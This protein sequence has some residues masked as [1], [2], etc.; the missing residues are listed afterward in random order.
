MKPP[1]Q[2]QFDADGRLTANGLTTTTTGQFPDFGAAQLRNTTFTLDAR[3][4][5]LSSSDPTNYADAQTATYSGLG[6]ALTSN[7]TQQGVTSNGGVLVMGSIEQYTV[8]VMGNVLT[9]SGAIS[10]QLNGA[11]VPGGSNWSYSR[12]YSQGRITGE[13]STGSRV[14]EYDGAGSDQWQKLVGG[15]PASPSEHRALRYGADG[16][17][18]RAELGWV[19]QTGVFPAAPWKESVEDYAYDALGRRVLVAKTTLCVLGVGDEATAC[20]ASTAV[21][22]TVWDGT[23]ELAEIQMPND[24]TYR[25]NDTGPVAVTATTSSDRNRYYGRVV[26]AHGPAVDQPLSVTRF[27]YTDYSGTAVVEWPTFTLVPLPNWRSQSFLVAF[28]NGDLEQPFTAGGTSCALT[29]AQRCVYVPSPAQYSMWEQQRGYVPPAWHGTLIEDKRESL[30]GLTY[31]RNRY[32]DQTTGRF[33]QEDPIGLAGGLNLYGFANGDPVNF[34][35]PFGLCVPP[36]ST[37]CRLIAMVAANTRGLIHLQPAMLAI[38]SL[39]TLGMGGGAL[40][41][42]SLGEAA[43][44]ATATARVIG[45]Y[46]GYL[47][48]GEAL[49]GKVF[50]VPAKIWNAM[51]ETAQWAANQKFLDR[52]IKEGAEFILSTLRS[53]IRRGSTLEKEVNYLMSKGYKWADN[54]MSLIPK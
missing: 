42:T 20:A 47:Q 33:T 5:V 1:G 37:E 53:E 22:R 13:L 3:G 18:R 26:Y 16:R 48:V 17:L 45:S 43:G 6:H 31:R 50:N 36:D 29:G 44:A 27:R 46:P 23:Q 30:V 10:M 28:G 35:D 8:D 39:P 11:V 25:E 51:S 7:V 41:L 38:A 34:S 2:G 52:G 24:A 15:G 40:A 49:G 12:S 14:F 54:G 19:A 21:R 9:G 4:K 32:Y